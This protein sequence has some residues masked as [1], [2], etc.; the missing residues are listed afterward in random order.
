LEKNQ[1]GKKLGSRI[2][3]LREKK[4]ISIREFE[5]YEKS[6]T[7]QVLSK[8]E[9]GSTIPTAYTLY[10]IAQILEVP[11]SDLFKDIDK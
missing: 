4:G 1:F 10:R 3:A 5:T 7:R 8:I 2:R 11:L 9:N 6:V